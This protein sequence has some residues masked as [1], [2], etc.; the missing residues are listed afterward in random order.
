MNKVIPFFFSNLSFKKNKFFFDFTYKF[1][2]RSG[3]S[4]SAPSVALAACCAAWAD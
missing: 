4:S 3:T 1:S 2:T